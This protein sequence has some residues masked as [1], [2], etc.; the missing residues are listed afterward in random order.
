VHASQAEPEVLRCGWASFSSAPLILQCLRGGAGSGSEWTVA[1]THP[2]GL[3]PRLVWPETAPA[4][5]S[6]ILTWAPRWASHS[7]RMA[8]EGESVGRSGLPG[9]ATA[10]AWFGRAA[11]LEGVVRAGVRDHR[12]PAVRPQFPLGAEAPGRLLS[13]QQQ[14]HAY[15][16][17]EGDREQS[18][19][20]SIPRQCPRWAQSSPLG[21]CQVV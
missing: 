10:T 20:G 8:P 18:L 1:S 14:R 12:E 7:M 15:R 3:I 16:P 9:V 19:P 13:G 17:Q 4:E 6:Q 11:L 2:F 5:Q 21:T